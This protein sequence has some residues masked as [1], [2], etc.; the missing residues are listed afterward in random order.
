MVTK[1]PRKSQSK[2]PEEEI[3][4]FQIYETEIFRLRAVFKELCDLRFKPF[5]KLTS[6]E[7]KLT[8][9]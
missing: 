2:T 8:S 5:D 6:K 4:G 1:A 7:K 9:K 3:D